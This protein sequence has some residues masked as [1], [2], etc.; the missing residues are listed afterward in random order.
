MEKTSMTEPGKIGTIQCICVVK[1]PFSLARQDTN[2]RDYLCSLRVYSLP[3][4]QCR[5]AFFC[6]KFCL[7]CPR[8]SAWRF[9][10]ASSSCSGAFLPPFH[11]H[12]HF[13]KIVASKTPK[14]AT[15]SRDS[16]C[17]VTCMCEVSLLQTLPP[18]ADSLWPQ[19]P[20]LCAFSS[21]MHLQSQERCFR[22]DIS[23]N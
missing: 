16:F 18:K 2:A 23:L 15:T 8:G 20:I 4:T 1:L 21:D 6:L 22:L 19:L 11:R 3:G 7:V 13:H 12:R 14:T 9:P 5:N 17:H 10:A